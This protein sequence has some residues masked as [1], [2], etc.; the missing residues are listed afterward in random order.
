MVLRAG[1]GAALL[2]T[3]IGFLAA[4]L[5]S[6]QKKAFR[7]AF[8][9][10]KRAGAYLAGAWSEFLLRGK[11]KQEKSKYKTGFEPGK[12][13]GASVGG[14][15]ARRMSGASRQ[16]VQYAAQLLAQEIAAYNEE[17]M[18]AYVDGIDVIPQALEYVAGGIRALA[19]SALQEQPLDPSV[20][21]FINGGANGL[22]NL[23]NTMQHL[24]G[25]IEVKHA[26]DLRKL[27]EH[28]RPNGQKWD[29]TY[30][31]R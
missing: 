22:S 16:R 19:V 28:T 2:G 1:R 15:V 8:P 3:G 17:G 26:D 31:R 10:T 20:G 29:H 14:E 24:R 30:N 21:E 9:H 23:G 27:R 6:I 12:S 18:L 13:G 11:R 7:W 25:L 4:G 5:W